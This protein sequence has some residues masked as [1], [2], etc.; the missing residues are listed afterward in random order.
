MHL[1]DRSRV[2]YAVL[3]VA[4]LGLIACG[5]TETIIQTV[6]VPVDRVVTEQ[7]IQTVEVEKIVTE[8]VVQTVEVEKIV[9]QQVVQTV[10]VDKIVTQ[11]V[12]QTVVVDKIVEVDKIVNREVLVEVTAV[13]ETAAPSFFGLPIPESNP[14]GADLP[15][16]KSKSGTAIMRVG[17][18]LSGSGV[19][20]EG[21]FSGF[22]VDEK[23][24]MTD[25][26]GN[27]VPQVVESWDLASDLSSVTMKFKEGVPFHGGYGNLSSADVVWSYNTGNP[28]FTPE[29]TTDGGA[30]WITFLG[31]QPVVAIDDFTVQ[32]PIA[33][34][35]VRWD[36]FMFGQSGLAL[37]I[38]SK[39]AFDQNGEDWARENVIGTGPFQVERYVRN[40]VLEVS[41]VKPHH[42]A[43]P[44]IDTLIVQSIPD[45]SVAEAALTT[46]AIDILSGTPFNLRNVGGFTADGFS[47][48]SAGA[49]S[50]HSISFSG[51]YWQRTNYKTGEDLGANFTVR[52]ALPWVGDPERDSFG[53]P[54][55]GMTNMDRAKIVRKALSL[56]IDRVAIAEVL[57]GGAGWPGYIYGADFNNP[58]WDDKWNLEFDPKRAEAMLDEAGYERD[59]DGIRFEMPFFIRLGRGDE[60]IGTA[61]VGMWRE[62]GI[63]MQD[64]KAQY[65]TYRPNLVGRTAT[66]PWIHS[67]GAESPQAPWD[68][69]VMGNSECSSGRGG[70]NIGI[71]IQEI[72]EFGTAMSSE[73]DKAKRIE[74]RNDINDFLFEWNPVIATI[75]VPQ[76]ALANP[77][78]VASWDMP[79]SVR[80]AQ[81]HH[82]EFLVLK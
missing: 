10:E 48:L 79:L 47:V 26:G 82:P 80:E 75:A 50:F 12:V 46:G 36:T 22:S 44:S 43:T 72:C 74:L 23:P 5:T 3:A 81:V 69:P 77:N 2:V 24:F 65:T 76:I 51:N 73:P 1:I 54:P 19:P 13:P 28:G 8:Q 4:M 16:P 31:D 29:S 71:E 55:E 39:A 40:D 66:A 68:W 32:F 62:I 25:A 20:G 57:T 56:A 33:A 63:D 61:V 64:W 59:D 9:T 27:A 18:E 60:E 52:H 49:G 17:P 70:F 6:E 45:T 34:F 42:R 38:T 53:N 35:D 67:A 15:A 11:Q 58:N 78:K 7:V 30:N 21:A 41:A 14:S 37:T